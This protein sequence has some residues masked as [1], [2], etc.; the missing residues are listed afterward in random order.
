M[1][2]HVPFNYLSSAKE[3]PELRDLR[4]RG[5]DVLEKSVVCQRHAD[6][7]NES[8]HLSNR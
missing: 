5:A 1:H 8:F 4:V 2:V 3:C 6:N 7:L